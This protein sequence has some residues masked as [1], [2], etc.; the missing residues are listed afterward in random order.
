MSCPAGRRRGAALRRGVKS[1]KG[2]AMN[3]NEMFC[4][5]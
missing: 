3:G 2:M 5:V 1:S 4:L